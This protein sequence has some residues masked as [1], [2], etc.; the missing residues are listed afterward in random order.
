MMVM[1]SSLAGASNPTDPVSVAEA[2]TGQPPSLQPCL[3]HGV[4]WWEQMLHQYLSLQT[5]SGNTTFKK[6]FQL[7]VTHLY[8][9]H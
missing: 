1:G 5:P 4:L 3:S 7:V 2:Y 8:S 6:K 9:I